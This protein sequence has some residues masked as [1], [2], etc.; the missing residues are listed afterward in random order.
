ME[1][2]LKQKQEAGVAIGD[3]I[4]QAFNAIKRLLAGRKAEAVC[5]ALLLLMAANLFGQISRKSLTNDEMIHIPAGYYHLVAGEFQLTPLVEKIGRAHLRF[6]H[7][8]GLERSDQLGDCWC[9]GPGRSAN[10]HVG[11]R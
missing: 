11:L 7:E 10:D 3:S 4:A 5:A 9:I 8:V 1:D 6:A 2:A